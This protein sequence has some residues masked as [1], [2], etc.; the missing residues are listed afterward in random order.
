MLTETIESLYHLNPINDPGVCTLQAISKDK[1]SLP[2]FTDVMKDTNVDG[3][4]LGGSIGIAIGFDWLNISEDFNHQIIFAEKENPSP[5]GKIFTYQIL[6]DIP[7]DAQ[8]TRGKIIRAYDNRE[9]ILKVTEQSGA[10]RIIGNNERGADFSAELNS[11]SVLKGPSRNVCGFT[12]QS[13]YRA[14]YATY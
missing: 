8:A 14:F 3:L 12:W 4:I 2:T 5:H 11:G 1:A 13:H 7:N 6:F 9:W 10:I